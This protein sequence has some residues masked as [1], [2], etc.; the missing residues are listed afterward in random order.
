M[1]DFIFA[2]ITI[3]VCM[4]RDDG[5][6]SRRHTISRKITNS[7]RKKKNNKILTR[8]MVIK[9]NMA[10]RLRVRMILH[11]SPVICKFTRKTREAKHNVNRG[12][13]NRVFEIRNQLRRG[14]TPLF[15]LIMRRTRLFHLSTH[16]APSAEDCRTLLYLAVG[17]WPGEVSQQPDPTD[18]C[19]TG[20][21]RK[22]LVFVECGG[23]LRASA[24]H[25][26]VNILL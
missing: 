17:F 15:V 10:K 4:S 2:V 7:R 1:V 16:S 26:I 8:L 3:I 21:A 14:S 25:S 24:L 20:P 11:I 23:I 6:Y 22:V 5:Q 13:Q 9:L 12:K 18:H 19:G